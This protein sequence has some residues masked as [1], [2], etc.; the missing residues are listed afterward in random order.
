SRRDIQK[1]EDYASIL[2]LFG[3]RL[4][5]DLKW[6]HRNEVFEAA[7]VEYIY[8]E[9]SF[10]L[11]GLFNAIDI[12]AD[13]VDGSEPNVA[14]SKLASRAREVFALQAKAGA[15]LAEILGEYR[16]QSTEQ[17]QKYNEAMEEAERGAETHQ[18]LAI[19]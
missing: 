9:A 1:M 17:W 14:R 15:R 12:I 5:K 10:V 8:N 2:D 11:H 19:Q 4:T 18:R 7:A 3:G 6:W 13:D 16:G